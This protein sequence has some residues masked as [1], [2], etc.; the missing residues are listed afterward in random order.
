M[1]KKFND[2]VRPGVEEVRA[3]PR[4]ESREL[5]KLDFPT[6]E[7]P[8]NAI[9]GNSPIGQSAAWK[10][11]CRNSALI[12][13]MLQPKLGAQTAC[14]PQRLWR[15]AA[16]KMPALPVPA[17]SSACAGCQLGFCHP[18]GAHLREFL[19]A[20]SHCADCLCV[21]RDSL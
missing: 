20:L 21:V 7:R 17:R 19:H 10:L 15:V 3:R 4:T 14:L 18:L 12:I 1:R 8:M 16:G 11:L 9:S 13:F 2:C 6:F 5:I